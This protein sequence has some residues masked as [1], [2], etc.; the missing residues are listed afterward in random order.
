MESTCFAADEADTVEYSHTDFVPERLQLVVDKLWQLQGQGQAPT[1]D[2][3]ADFCRLVPVMQGHD[4]ND[5]AHKAYAKREE[6]PVQI[7]GSSGTTG[8]GKLVLSRTQAPGSGPSEDDI[9]LITELRTI[10]A[11][12]PGDVVANL[13]MVGL[14][15]LLHQGFNR[16]LEA[17]NCSIVP[18]GTLDPD[19]VG[20]QLDFL[21][22]YRVN[23][24]AG[25]PGTLIQVAD[26]VRKS[27]V[28]LEIER[29][30]FT[31]ERMGAVKASVLREVFKGTR[32]IGCYGYSECGFVGIEHPDGRYRVR[33]DAYFLERD[34]DGRL[35][36]SCLDVNLPTPVVRYDTGDQVE[37]VEHCGQVFLDGIER[38]DSS[39]NFIGNLIDIK[40]LRQLAGHVLCRED[41][42]FEVELNT[43]ADG[44]DDL[45][46]RVLADD[47]DT[48]D[49]ERI[50][51]Q[52]LSHAEIREAIDK[53]AGTVHVECRPPA[54][55]NLSGR[56]K[57]R[58]IID[59]RGDL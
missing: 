49:C 31:G 41:L 24:L 23:V 17:C 45:L 6:V 21:R 56:N 36:V 15:S 34:P 39:F 50:R 3:Y 9:Q 51:D 2:S 26:A 16:L 40:T 57:H 44:T 1:I 8:K 25:T 11:L 19:Q 42:I 7:G 55:A 38:A 5:I 52:L 20:S 48:N 28:K 13:F 32:I 43:R 14:F 10:G 35:L 4:Y 54:E 30:L 59:N 18:L 37:F 46:V 29:I 58:Q 47:V 33:D 22:R 12:G 27:G 53:Q